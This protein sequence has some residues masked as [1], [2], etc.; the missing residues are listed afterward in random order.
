MRLKQYRPKTWCQL[1]KR[2]GLQ[3]RAWEIIMKWLKS[4]IQEIRH[5]GKINKMRFS[6][7]M[8]Y[9]TLTKYRNRKSQT[10]AW[11]QKIILK[12]LVAPWNTVLCETR[13]KE[14]TTPGF[15]A[16]WLVWSEQNTQE[17]YLDISTWLSS[18]WILSW[19]SLRIL[20]IFW[21]RCFSKLYIF[22]LWAT[23][24]F[25]FSMVMR[26]CW[27]SSY[28]KQ[29]GAVC[30]KRFSRKLQQTVRLRNWLSTRIGIHKK[31]ADLKLC[32][33]FGINLRK[34]SPWFWAKPGDFW[35]KKHAEWGLRNWRSSKRI[36]V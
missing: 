7:G 2:W 29:R 30:D 25:N 17:E 14:S 13:Y 5:F 10:Q 1:L 33:I 35:K 24:L 4:K 21:R 19:S 31:R 16:H 15:R 27:S 26:A 36:R 32:I 20:L 22:C 3:T 11:K 28:T 9:V 34:K 8:K 6:C 18:S 12:L 23:S